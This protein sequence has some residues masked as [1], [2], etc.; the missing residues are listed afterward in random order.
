[1]M[2]IPFKTFSACMSTPLDRSSILLEPL[3]IEE[4]G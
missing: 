4:E 1:M 3:A 2:I